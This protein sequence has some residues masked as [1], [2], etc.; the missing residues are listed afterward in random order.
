MTESCNPIVLSTDEASRASEECE[1][2]GTSSSEII[3]L[4]SKQI[5]RFA[6]GYERSDAKRQELAQEMLLAVWQ[7][8]KSFKQQCSLRTWIYRVAH[9]VATT[10]VQ[11]ELRSPNLVA[12]EDESLVDADS[13]ASAENIADPKSDVPSNLDAKRQLER[14][15]NLINSLKTPD[16]QI[17]LLYLEDVDAATIAD[18]VGLSARNVATKIHRIKAVLANQANTPHTSTKKGGA[19]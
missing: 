18:V 19:L 7:S 6:M 17:M 11:R 16:R 13:R 5:S 12:I 15:L 9:N 3:A 14:L 1:R 2:A 10:H 8:L 4:Y